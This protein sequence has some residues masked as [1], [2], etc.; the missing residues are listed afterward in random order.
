MFYRIDL[1]P[2]KAGVTPFIFFA[3]RKLINSN[4]NIK[5]IFLLENF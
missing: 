2:S 1:S 5:N 4:K 3:V